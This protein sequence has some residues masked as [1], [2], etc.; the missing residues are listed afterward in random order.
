MILPKMSKDKGYI[1]NTISFFVKIERFIY[2]INFFTKN[3]RKN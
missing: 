3:E 2:K 1:E